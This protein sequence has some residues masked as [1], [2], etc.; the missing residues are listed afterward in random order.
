MKPEIY[1]VVDKHPKENHAS[2]QY[3][4]LCFLR[5]KKIFSVKLDLVKTNKCFI[6]NLLRHSM[7]AQI[8]EEASNK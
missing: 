7:Q 8:I 4:T 2:S 5:S 3:Y 1:T 6:Y